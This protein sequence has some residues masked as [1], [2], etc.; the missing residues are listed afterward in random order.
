MKLQFRND[1]N[2]MGS[3]KELGSYFN[4]TDQ[5]VLLRLPEAAELR[6]L[7]EDF[8]REVRAQVFG[9]AVQ[10][11][12]DVVGKLG[13]LK[14]RSG[15]L[16]A[17]ANTLFGMLLSNENN[18]AHFKKRAVLEAVMALDLVPDLKGDGKVRKRL[19]R[20]DGAVI[21]LVRNMTKLQ[22]RSV[23]DTI[24]HQHEDLDAWMPVRPGMSVGWLGLKA[25]VAKA[26]DVA[27]FLAGLA[28]DVDLHMGKD[29]SVG[30][31][32]TPVEYAPSW[33]AQYL[34][35]RG[36]W[37]WPPRYVSALANLYP[38]RLSP[39]MVT[40]S[41]AADVRPLAEA[42]FR[43]HQDKRNTGSGVACQAF[44]MAALAGNTWELKNGALR[45]YPLVAFKE[46]M[47]TLKSSKP[48]SASVNA[49]YRL[50]VEQA[51]GT[52]KGRPEAHFFVNSARIALIGV[53]AFN[54]VLAPTPYNTQVASKLLGHPVTEIPENVRSWAAQLRDI[55]PLLKVKNIKGPERLMGLWLIYLMKID[56]DGNAPTDFQSIRRHLHVHDLN[57][58]NTS[59]FW[60][61]LSA[62]PKD[63]RDQGNRAI[64]AMKHAF[65]RAAQKD[66]FLEATNPFDTKLDRIGKLKG[67]SNQ[68]R[69]RPLALEAWELIVRRNRENGYAFA[70]SLGPK[71][72]HYRLR[73]L[74]T[75]LY[76]DVF[77]P[78]E[79]VVVDII[80]NSGMRHVSA[81][82]VDSGEGDGKRI[83]RVNMAL[84]DNDHPSAT[85]GRNECFLQLEDL[86]GQGAKVMG[87]RVGI[88]KTGEPYNIPWVDDGVVAG[89]DLMLGLQ[90]KYNPISQPV[91]Q[92]KPKTLEITR[93][94]PH[95]YLD[96]YP[97]FRDPSRED[98]NLAISEAKVI[99]YWK[100]LLWHCQDEVNKLFGRPYPLI[101]DDGLV[102]DLHA[103][104]VTMVSNL[105]EAGVSPKLIQDLVGH[106]SAMMTWYYNAYRS[107]ALNTSIQGAMHKRSQAHDALA[108]GDKKQ[109]NAYADEAVVPDVHDHVGTGMLREYGRKTNLAPF[110]V[111]VHGICPGGTCS[112][113][114]ARYAGDKYQP[115]WRERACAGCRYHVTGPKFRDGIQNK[116]NNLLVE[117]E[118]VRERLSELSIE[119]EI[120][121]AETGRED[122]V[123]QNL[124]LADNGLLD[125]LTREL[126]MQIR[127]RSMVEE[128]ERATLAKGKSADNLLVP[129]ISGFDPEKLGFG[130]A[131]VSRYEL[132]HTSVKETRILPASIMEL[133]AG[134]EAQLKKLTKRILI[135]N[136]Q[137]D[138]LLRLS[139]RQETDACLAVGDI[140]LDRYPEVAQMK[141]LLDGAVR[142]DERLLEDVRDTVE[143]IIE[144]MPSKRLMLNAAE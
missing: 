74:E 33:F 120:K 38:R 21:P 26:E 58:Q 116:V 111:F 143:G 57:G 5:M 81:R 134:A 91:K 34:A 13:S 66:R 9:L 37:V 14:F 75:G 52:V 78:A 89:F 126:S 102:F 12:G 92:I 128:V 124:R 72:C 60:D 61:F 27:A 47:P 2:L 54:W 87:Q 113:G 25:R 55:L 28:E 98:E 53:D 70:R 101:T 1:Q 64:A 79:A 24:V 67:K 99:S 82:W 73:N 62:M 109:I 31:A 59:T 10:T 8:D 39:L 105:F 44:A 7:W 11:L 56:A 90:Q 103:L 49:I 88:N 71:R 35:A 93:A 30:T 129:A 127:L 144:S 80:L 6:A 36:I 130:I 46:R 95:D 106:A 138:I 41:V 76:E 86:P 19:P 51:G 15:T 3:A 48:L 132:I 112:T 136:N 69:R 17:E 18:L 133:P 137:A 84:E 110:T 114:G 108:A 135:N 119:I 4:A 42:V 100:D 50:A 131:E 117:I 68:T 94:D 29:E 85:V 77:W 118:L 104:R 23:I 141:A 40:M 20:G 123:L 139:D 115:V 45:W 16:E 65:N 83:N 122:H 142:L 96:I 140:L 97:L 32:E 125:H 107:S 22:Q 121:E 63:T 43:F